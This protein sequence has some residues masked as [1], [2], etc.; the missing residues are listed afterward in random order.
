MQSKKILHVIE[1]GILLILSIFIFFW[2]IAEFDP[3][4]AVDG[5]L[6]ISG[7]V[8]FPEDYSNVTSIYFNGWNTLHQISA[9]LLKI[10]LSQEII[11]WLFV[12]SSSFALIV[13]LYLILFSLS[14]SKI[15]SFLITLVFFITQKHLGHVD[16]PTLTTSEHTYGLFTFSLFT[17]ITGTLAV[18]NFKL[19]G[20]L[21]T[22]L[23][24]FHLIAGLWSLGLVI[25]IF[26]LNKLFVKKDS[27]VFNQ[28]L[29]GISFGFV[30]IIISFIFFYLNT[31]PKTLADNDLFEVYMQLWDH[32][33]NIKHVH[34]FYLIKSLILVSFCISGIFL[35]SKRKLEDLFFLY[36]ISS[37]ILIS[38]VIYL[39]YKFYGNYFPELITRTMPT[40]LVGLHSVMGYL[41]IIGI[42]MKFI[43]VLGLKLNLSV[44]IIYSIFFIV[45]FSYYAFFHH[46]KNVFERI[47]A[48]IEQKVMVRIAKFNKRISNNLD[49]DEVV[50][51]DYIKDKNF[52]GYVVTNAQTTNLTLR[53]GL[54]PYIINASFIDHLPYHP[55][56][57]SQSILIIEEIYG[58]D[59]EN[60]PS[61][62]RGAIKDE[63]YKIKF[64]KRTEEEWKNLSEEFNLSAIILPNEWDLNLNETISSSKYS[65]YIF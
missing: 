61:L 42:C 14:E 50:F 22:I 35:F 24:G 13:G 57:V 32:H 56:T 33:R 65:L 7:K 54:K 28:I 39:L 48:I 27:E 38:S 18:K 4:T 31:I 25:F 40:R 49:K 63:W 45:L 43:K 34:S 9:L 15:I 2:S 10:G 58:V 64:E 60:P 44:N 30:L 37:S 59:F 52:K 19:S 26:L 47:Q 11:S 41:I 21:I 5:G 12:F 20:F 36:F 8:I 1:K 6:I 29:Q 55:Y 16:Y 51:W 3:Q 53:K 46:Q 23:M 62:Y 17:L